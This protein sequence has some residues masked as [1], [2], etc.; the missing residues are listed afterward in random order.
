MA[1]DDVTDALEHEDGHKALEIAN[2]IEAKVFL[3]QPV[4][5]RCL[6]TKWLGTLKTVYLL[7]TTSIFNSPSAPA[8]GTAA[9]AHAAGGGSPSSAQL[10][11]QLDFAAAERA[12][13]KRGIGS[14][15]ARVVLIVVLLVVQLPLLLPAAFYPP[16]ED[17]LGRRRWYLLKAPVV[18]FGL[19]FTM[20]M[21][22]AAFV[23]FTPN[24]DNHHAGVGR[25]PP[26]AATLLKD[27]AESPWAYYALPWALA[28]LVWEV[29]HGCN[30]A[31][32]HSPLTSSPLPSH[33]ASHLLSPLTSSHLRL[34]SSLTLCASKAFCTGF[35]ATTPTAS[36]A[37]TSPPRSSPSSRRCG[38][39]LT[40]RSTRAQTRAR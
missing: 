35:V 10:P 25:P 14:E 1:A 24:W 38:P 26:S 32:Y 8:D 15:A 39:S 18:K 23:T 22:F 17:V 31:P 5:R 40:C 13:L 19:A 28:S 12:A 16:L 27:P 2:M 33:L 37:S 36:T 11:P 6:R 3:S 20:D 21:A 30:G 9:A 34:V 29:R 7:P 4:V